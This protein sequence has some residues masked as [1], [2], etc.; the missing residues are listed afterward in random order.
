MRGPAK[1]P[2]AHHLIISTYIATP[3][4]D[5]L[6]MTV[7]LG[8][9]LTAAADRLFTGYGPLVTAWMVTAPLAGACLYFL[10]RVSW[11]V[12][13]AHAGIILAATA[14]TFALRGLGNLSSVPRLSR[15]VFLAGNVIRMAFVAYVLQRDFRAPY[16][17]VLK[18]SFRGA[19]RLPLRLPI[20]VNSQLCRTGDL[21]AAGCF[22]ALP[23]AAPRV[24]DRVEVR[25]DYGGAGVK[26]MGQVMRATPEGVG[27]RFL[28]LSRRERRAL[29]RSLAR[30]MPVPQVS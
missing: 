23:E 25:L 9:P 28:G 6:M 14:L 2:V 10:N 21:S 3:L 24:G 27:V 30:R 26:C 1:R 17:R 16:F 4:I 8:I 13:L 11:Y 19:K 29:R 22:V 18:S 12:F 15:D 5:L 7:A 20:L